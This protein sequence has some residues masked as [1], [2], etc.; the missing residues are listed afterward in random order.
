[1]IAIITLRWTHPLKMFSLE[2]EKSDNI[3]NMFRQCQRQL[4]DVPG[5]RGMS[6]GDWISFPDKKETFQLAN[7]GWYRQESYEVM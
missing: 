6:Y 2:V 3:H 5:I 1:M 4:S 7:D